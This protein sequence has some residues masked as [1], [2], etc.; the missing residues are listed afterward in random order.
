MQ[1]QI[2]SQITPIQNNV[3]NKNTQTFLSEWSI[4]IETCYSTVVIVMINALTLIVL[5]KLHD[6][7]VSTNNY[8]LAKNAPFIP[9]YLGTTP[10]GV[11]LDILISVI[12]FQLFTKKLS[13]MYEISYLKCCQRYT[14]CFKLFVQQDIA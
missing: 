1:I 4:Y 10:N 2:T 14:L 5:N 12:Y 8:G 3:C 11:S 13:K 6:W 9:T 7:S